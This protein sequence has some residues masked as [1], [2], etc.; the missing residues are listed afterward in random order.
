MTSTTVVPSPAPG[1]GRRSPAGDFATLDEI[2]AAALAGLDPSVRDFLQG[3]AGAETTLARNRAAFDRWAY[4]PR[5]MSGLD[6]PDLGT[7]FLGIPLTMPVLTA[8][9]GADGLFHPEGHR[10]VA[11]ADT[12]AG[13][14]DIVPEAG[15]HPV[16]AVAAA[17]R[18]VDGPA[19]PSAAIG[20]FHPM[21][22]E[23]NVI[24]M[25][26]R[27]E[28]A[29]YRALC[30]TC[31]C[32]TA[33]WRERNRR[34]RFSPDSAVVGG[35]YPADSGV[36][37]DE[38]FGQLFTSGA[39]VWGWDELAGLMARTELPWIAKGI[40]TPEDAVAAVGA[41]AAGV[42]VSNHGG[43]QLDGVLAS[44]DALPAIRSAVGPDVAIALDSGIRRG[45][46]V[47]TA[48]ALGA[49]VVV[50][51]RLAAYGLAAGGAV[52]VLRVLELLREEVTTVLSLLGR[53]GIADLDA[54]ALTRVDR[55]AR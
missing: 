42:L 8:P 4:R 54:D 23:D 13:I 11:R 31:D 25:I 15:T 14:A 7:S 50:I 29:G 37:L 52:G 35:N 30:V 28:D 9:F 5:V 27:Y 26:R 39:S 10:A 18:E 19:G 51:G 33:G 46:D 21:G 22:A 12:L 43:R 2:E 32:P 41:G 53:G 20:Q 48:V 36:A 3:G 38:V 40:L 6:V 44:L 34:N 55:A 1:D 17:A 16:E 49:D 24:A 45:T 47:V